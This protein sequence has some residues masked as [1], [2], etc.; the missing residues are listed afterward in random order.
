MLALF[1]PMLVSKMW[2]VS[3][4]K[5]FKSLQFFRLQSV[6]LLGHVTPY[7]S[8]LG[9]E[10]LS[11]D[12]GCNYTAKASSNSPMKGGVSELLGVI[13]EE[14]RAGGPRILLW[15]IDSL[16]KRLVGSGRVDTV[17]AV[18]KQLKTIRLNPNVYTYAIM[19]T[20]YYWNNCFEEAEN[21]LSEMEAAGVEPDSFMYFAYLEGL[22]MNGL[23]DS[24]YKVLQSCKAG[25]VPID[26]YSYTTVIQDFVNEKKL[27]EVVKVLLDMEEYEM[28]PSEANYLNQ[29]SEFEKLGKLFI[30]LDKVTYNVVIDCSCKMGWLDEALILFDEMRKRTKAVLRADIIIY[31]VHVVGILVCNYLA[32]SVWKGEFEKAITLLEILLS[33]GDGPTKTMYLKLIAALCG[34]AFDHMVSRGLVPDVVIYTIMMN[35]YCRVNHLQEALDL[36]TT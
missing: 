26:A 21:V 20:A 33:I 19:I 18:Y 13:A 23:T 10:D 1:F 14:L 24:G 2:S 35:D 16:I 32:P 11:P 25:N 8:D 5:L 27:R 7:F 12:M 31:N 30:Y 28:I 4:K 17:V 9:F 34:A 15:A 36:F 6:P 29:F 3:S 22:C